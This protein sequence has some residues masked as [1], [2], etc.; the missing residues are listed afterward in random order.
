M[1]ALGAGF[2]GFTFFDPEIGKDQ[3]QINKFKKGL[4]SNI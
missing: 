1:L 3:K 2:R 4:H